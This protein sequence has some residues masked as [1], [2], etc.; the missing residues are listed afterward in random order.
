LRYT[1]TKHLNQFLKPFLKPFSLKRKT[2]ERK[3]WV[4]P[5]LCTRGFPRSLQL[6]PACQTGP[7]DSDTEQGR[8]VYA[9]RLGAISPATSIPARPRS[10]DCPTQQCATIGVGDGRVEPSEVAR[11][12]T[13]RHGGGARRSAGHLRHA[14]ARLGLNQALEH[15][16]ERD[17]RERRR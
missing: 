8:R 2:N 6:G 12:R 17:G 15:T 7:R 13:W 14:E 10:P 4:H 1:F 3:R 5:V 9:T 16:G 11:R